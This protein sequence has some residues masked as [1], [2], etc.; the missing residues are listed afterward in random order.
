MGMVKMTLP[1]DWREVVAMAADIALIIVLDLRF[2]SGPVAL[3]VD[4]VFSSG[5][6][7]KT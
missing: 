7:Y 5:S 3:E 4:R 6:E 2:D 1:E